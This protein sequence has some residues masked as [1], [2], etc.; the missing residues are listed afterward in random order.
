MVSMLGGFAPPEVLAIITDQIQKISNG[1]QGGLLTLGFLLAIWSS[2]AAMTA[3]IDTLNHAYDIEEGRPC[4]CTACDRSRRTALQ[5]SQPD[6]AHGVIPPFFQDEIRALAGRQHVLPQINQV[7]VPPDRASG[8][9]RFLRRQ[10]GVLVE[11]R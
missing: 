1:E 5:L 11:I 10:I 3:I 8:L 6:L 4:R 9:G 7:N 2:S